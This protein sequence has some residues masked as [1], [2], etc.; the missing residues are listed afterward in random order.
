M[1]CG[2]HNIVPQDSV[3]QNTLVPRL[4]NASHNAQNERGREWSSITWVTRTTS[5]WV[6]AGILCV[7]T[8]LCKYARLKP[9]SNQSQMGLN[10]AIEHLWTSANWRLP[11]ALI[12]RKNMNYRFLECSRSISFLFDTRGYILHLLALDQSIELIEM[13]TSSAKPEEST[14]IHLYR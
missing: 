9:C 7:I 14:K 4:A 8:G 13:R 6:G 12:N 11:T 3:P 5:S 2:P 10:P 1:S